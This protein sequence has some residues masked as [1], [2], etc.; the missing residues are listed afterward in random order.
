VPEPEQSSYAV[1]LTW[2]EWVSWRRNKLDITKQNLTQVLS[3]M[4]FDTTRQTLWR[5]ET[6]RVTTTPE[7]R[8]VIE[9]ALDIVEAGMRRHVEAVA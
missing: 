2:A 6:G 9:L 5:I 4:G 7:T 1:N 3:A 8:Q